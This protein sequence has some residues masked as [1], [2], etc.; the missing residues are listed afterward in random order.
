M[1]V[2][3]SPVQS[4]AS[5]ARD[6][7]FG[8]TRQRRLLAFALLLCGT[9]LLALASLATAQEG[10]SPPAP[11]SGGNILLASS[12]FTATLNAD[13]ISEAEQPG[14]LSRALA[15][16]D[17]NSDNTPELSIEKSAPTSVFN[18]AAIAYTITLK[19]ISAATTLRNIAVRDVL[20][21]GA[22]RSIRCD[23]NCQYIIESTQISEP[24]GGTIV[25]TETRE[26][27]WTV[28]ILTP[29][30][31]MVLHIYGT[32]VGQSEGSIK[33]QAFAS[34]ILNNEERIASTAEVQ[35]QV[36]VSTKPGVG[37]VL[38]TA[39]NWFSN[40]RGGTLDQDLGRL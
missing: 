15:E 24:L 5:P 17:A 40:D 21:R 28:P 1:T 25:V 33:N 23:R 18:G 36:S 13:E 6:T 10:A 8:I 29:G 12:V 35:T 14:W 19:N 3:S 30:L 2:N 11:V 39:P 22:L 37:A 4:Q 9:L 16:A 26:L 32:V 38:S 34:Y 31:E 27:S 7:V 20:P